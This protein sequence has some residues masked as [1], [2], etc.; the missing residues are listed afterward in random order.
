MLETYVT[1][2][3]PIFSAASSSTLLNHLLGSSPRFE[4]SLR[5]RAMRFGPAYGL[6]LLLMIVP[7]L[8][9][10]G[11]LSLGRLTSTLFPLF[12]YLGWQ[13]RAAPRAALITAFAGLQALLAV[14][15]FTWRPFF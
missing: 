1:V 3:R 7:P 12:L 14:L 15:F 9:R 8:L 2:S 6:F 4:A 10:G 13:V 5:R 11:F